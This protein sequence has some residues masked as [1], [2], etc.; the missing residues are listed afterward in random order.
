MDFVTGT[1]ELEEEDAKYA[2]TVEEPQTWYMKVWNWISK[3][4][5]YLSLLLDQTLTCAAP[6][7]VK[8]GS[9]YVVAITVTVVVSPRLRHLSK[10]RDYLFLLDGW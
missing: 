7:S 8:I 5:F 4:P 3:Q 1:R 9:D 10:I 6:C 2:A